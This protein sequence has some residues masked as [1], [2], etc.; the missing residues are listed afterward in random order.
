MADIHQSLLPQFSLQGEFFI[1]KVP[2]KDK[3]QR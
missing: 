1:G 3:D 2:V